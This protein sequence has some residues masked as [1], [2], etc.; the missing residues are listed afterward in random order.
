MTPN[1]Q[2][3]EVELAARDDL[4][5]QRASTAERAADVLRRL[6]LRGEL[7]PGS[8]V[9]E[10]KLAGTLGISPNTMREALRILGSEGL[11]VQGRHRVATVV[12]LEP[13]DVDEIFAV[14]RAL[15]LAAVDELAGSDR[16]PDLAQMEAAISRFRTFGESDEWLRVIDADRQFHTAVVALAGNGRLD[17]LYANCDAEI[18]LCLGITTRLHIDVEEL[19]RQH[20]ALLGLLRDGELLRL[21]ADLARTLDE[22]RDRVIAVLK[23]DR[24]VPD[25]PQ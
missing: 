7:Q 3:P 17:T 4:R 14:R 25:T 5:L 19:A 15:E 1:R 16:T 13:A 23:G 10:A 12:R 18:R 8:P 22:A 2:T 21:R 20:E 11:L 6:I 9:R 24:E